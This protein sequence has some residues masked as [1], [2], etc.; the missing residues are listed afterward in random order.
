MEGEPAT[1]EEDHACTRVRVLPDQ[2]EVQCCEGA[3]AETAQVAAAEEQVAES[4]AGVGQELE[5]EAADQAVDDAKAQLTELISSTVSE[6]GFLELDSVVTAREVTRSLCL[7]HCASLTVLTTLTAHLDQTIS[8]LHC[9]LF[10]R[11]VHVPNKTLLP[12]R[13]TQGLQTHLLHTNTGLCCRFRRRRWSCSRLFP[14][15]Q[16]SNCSSTLFFCRRQVSWEPRELYGPATTLIYLSAGEKCTST[17][18]LYTTPLYRT[19]IPHSIPHLY[20]APL[21][22]TLHRTL[23]RT[24]HCTSTLLCFSAAHCSDIYSC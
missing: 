19:S 10:R 7:S 24:L 14:S 12:A 20:T 11:P 16:A 17:L 8:F 15:L 2:S 9:P 23:R 21:Y 4:E 5:S 1:E 13:T 18:H 3:E 22:R 6:R